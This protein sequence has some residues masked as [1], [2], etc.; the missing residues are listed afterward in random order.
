MSNSEIRT[1]RYNPRMT[2]MEAYDLLPQELRDALKEGPAAWCALSVLN[3]YTKLRKEWSVSASIRMAHA[4]IMGW[5]RYEI[6][7]GQPW[8]QSKPR[9]RYRHL[10]PS[11]HVQAEATMQPAYGPYRDDELLSQLNAA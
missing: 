5:H 9:A 2:D 3:D 8:R 1:V 6:K 10:P 7:D 4:T 11:P